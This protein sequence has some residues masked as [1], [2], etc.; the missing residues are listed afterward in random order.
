LLVSSVVRPRQA[1]YQAALRP[2]MVYIFDSTVRFG[3]ISTRDNRG[4]SRAA[5]SDFR[6]VG[7]IPRLRMLAITV[8]RKELKKLHPPS[9]AQTL[10]Q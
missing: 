1:R 5:P 9:S 8:I 4:R 2:D 3:F 6:E 7:C 10:T